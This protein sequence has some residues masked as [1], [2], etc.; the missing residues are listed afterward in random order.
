[1]NSITVFSGLVAAALATGAPPPA[2]GC[3][4]A[5]ESRSHVVVLMANCSCTPTLEVGEIDCGPWD[6]GSC[7]YVDVD[8][9]TPNE[10]ECNAIVDC[11]NLVNC[12][13]DTGAISL[14]FDENCTV[15]GGDR[16]DV[17]VNGAFVGTFTA[18][19]TLVVNIGGDAVACT[20]ADNE[21][22][23]GDEVTVRLGSGG[24]GFQSCT[25]K[26]VDKC[27]KCGG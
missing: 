11:P 3:A 5:P 21:E 25:F 20:N 4:P 2:R 1:M 14:S 22:G 26:V 16:L 9:G 10:P 13:G 7:F 6:L 12:H 19:T 27:L 17:D 23:S 24:S 8:V 15:E 18:S